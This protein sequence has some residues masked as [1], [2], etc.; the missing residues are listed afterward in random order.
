MGR[1]KNNLDLNAFIFHL[2]SHPYERSL[3][4]GLMGQNN[5]YSVTL[6]LY[7]WNSIFLFLGKLLVNFHF[8]SHIY[9]QTS[10]DKYGHALSRHLFVF[11]CWVWIILCGRHYFFY[12]IKAR[13]V[14]CPTL[15][16]IW[17]NFLSTSISATHFKHSQI[18]KYHSQYNYQI[19]KFEPLMT[20]ENLNK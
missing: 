4:K 15:R 9:S 17:L 7:F 13:L 18:W 6:E 3:W 20:M 16:Y 12:P 14:F 2:A 19:L 5:W 1:W 8:T 11:C 10:N